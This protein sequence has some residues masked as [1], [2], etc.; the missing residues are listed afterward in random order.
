MAAEESKLARLLAEAR[1]FS[2]EFDP[3][4]AN[5]LPMV[6]VILDR[7]GAPPSRLEGFFE[8]Y[9]DAS[10]L[11]PAPDDQGR[12]HDVNWQ[13]HFGE[14]AYEGD[15]RGFFARQVQEQGVETVLRRHLPAL[16]P[17]IA[18]SALHAL[19]RAAYGRLQ[20]DAQEVSV[21]LGYWCATYLP[22]RFAGKSE[23]VTEDPVEILLRL[24]AIDELRDVHPDSDLLWRWMREVSRKAAFPPVA[25]WLR[26]GPDALDRIAAASLA[27]YAETMTFEALHALTGTHWL[28]LMRPDW[29]DEG[30]AVRYFWQAIAAVY[31]KIGMPDLPSAEALAAMR[32]L[33]APDWPEIKARA[34]ASDDEHDISLVFS[35]SEEERHRG[36][37]LYRVVAARR[38][39]LLA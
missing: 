16:V 23:P 1:G 18:A 19:M 4:L 26:A 7:L 2:V 21:A 5:H 14:R 10:G 6:L 8:T 9:R 31:P 38:V 37:Q 34:C 35:A 39:G 3:Y 33:P 36:D 27:F 29:P 24:Q 20:G 15:Y 32:E 30:L 25:D 11:K 22:L 13:A 12:I 28:R 17:G